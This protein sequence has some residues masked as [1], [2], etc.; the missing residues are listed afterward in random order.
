M[1]M[2][3]K[4]QQRDRT[5]GRSRTENVWRY[6]VPPNQG[7]VGWTAQR[8]DSIPK[9]PTQ[10]GEAWVGQPALSASFHRATEQIVG[11]NA[12]A[13]LGCLQ[14]SRLEVCTGSQEATLCFRRSRPASRMHSARKA[15]S[16]PTQ[17]RAPRVVRVEEAGLR[18]QLSCKPQCG[19]RSGPHTDGI[20][21]CAY[22]CCLFAKH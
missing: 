21:P 7:K 13:G 16:T 20:A 5:Y 4:N 17:G 8:R 15:E 10:A 1:R 14:S 6:L 3:R 18:C 9:Y 19:S 2:G 22:R 11:C 12:P